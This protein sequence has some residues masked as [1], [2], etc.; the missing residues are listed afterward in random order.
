M[1]FKVSEVAEVG[2]GRCMVPGLYKA[3]VSVVTDSVS[4]SGKD[5]VRFTLNV[6]EGSHKGEVMY[7]QILVPNSGDDESA[8]RRTRDWIYMLMSTG[9]TYKQASG[10]MKKGLD[11]DK[12]AGKSC[13]VDL[14][15]RE[16]GDRLFDEIKWRTPE[17]AEVQLSVTKEE[18]AEEEEEEAEEKGSPMD[19]FFGGDD[20]DDDIPF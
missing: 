20:D 14:S 11:T 2:A 1:K 4:S 19:E 13:F 5:M 16:V 3:K 15:K 10:L 7:T 17:Q 6:R 8:L 9:L 12:L 18:D